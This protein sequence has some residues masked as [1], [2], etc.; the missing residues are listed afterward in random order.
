MEA[1]RDNTIVI[2]PSFNEARTIGYIVKDIVERG[3]S[4]LVVDD[5]SLDNTERVAL[6]SG[7]MVMRHK[8][9]RGKGF[10]VR[11]GIKYVLGKT[12]FEWMVIMDGD[13][14]HH[15]EDIA[16]M[17]GATQKGNF[18]IINGNRMRETGTMPFSRYW[19]NRFTSWT[20]SRICN[21]YIPDTQCGFRL[22]KV[23]SLKGMELES[24]KYD[25]ESEMLIQ[26]A[27]NN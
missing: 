13:G 21:Q 16:V 14:Q 15:T 18:D 1:R 24:E 23:D 10:S 7:A 19:T 27:E 8:E 2:I 26:A 3:L 11:E 5:G 20:I 4:V 25:I 22:V 12:N 17:M 9:N 6:D